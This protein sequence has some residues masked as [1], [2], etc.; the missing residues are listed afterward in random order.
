R[1]SE[2]WRM[3]E[4]ALAMRSTR[5]ALR[6]ERERTRVAAVEVEKIEDKV[7][8]LVLGAFLKACLEIGEASG[9]IGTEDDDLAVEGAGCCGEAGDLIG[10]G[11]HAVGPVEA[12]ARK[13]LD[14]AAGFAG[15]DAVAV[16]LEL[17]QPTGGGRRVFGLLGE[18]RRKE[19]GLGFAREGS[20]RR[21]GFVG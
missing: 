17:M 16:E 20:E 4:L 15:L 10:D 12:L 8:E 1:W 5:R 21:S 19:G 7:R 3:S 9:A 6:G 13:E 2:R 18:L 11:L 14:L